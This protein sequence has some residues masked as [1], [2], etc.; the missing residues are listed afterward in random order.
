MKYAVVYDTKTSKKNVLKVFK[1]EQTAMKQLKLM[2]KSPSFKKLGS[3]ARLVK[4]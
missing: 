1:D 4:L 3:N 2:E